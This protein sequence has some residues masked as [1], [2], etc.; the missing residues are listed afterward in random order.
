MKTGLREAIVRQFGRPSGF[1]GRLVGLIMARRPSNLERN[2]RMIELLAIR[3]GDRVL[4]IGFGPG[5]A[6]E[7]AARR[8]GSGTV[9]GV[10]HS[11]LMRREASRR[12]RAA[13]AAGH[14]HLHLG[15]ADALPAFKEPFDVLMASNVH[16]FLDDPVATL[17]R[18]LAVMRP[19][20]RIA[21]THQSRKQAASNADTARDA[22]RIA[23]DLRAAGFTD[24]RIETLEMKPVNAACVLGRRP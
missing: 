13:I 8:V 14:V 12:N 7:M 20:S 21:L 17:R 4:E 18:W 22:E 10:D 5:V 11:E 9:V 15:S 6:I 19:G 2:R 24:V 23:A 3:D 16:L 1:V